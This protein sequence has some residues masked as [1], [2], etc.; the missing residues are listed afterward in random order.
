MREGHAKAAMVYTN[1]YAIIIGGTYRYDTDTVEVML[2]PNSPDD[3]RSNWYTG[4]ELPDALEELSALVFPGGYVCVYGG[5][6]NNDFG[7]SSRTYCATKP[8][9]SSSKWLRKDNLLN[10]RRFHRSIVA[11]NQI[12]HVGDSS[13]KPIEKW[14][15]ETEIG[16]WK[17]KQNTDMDFYGTAGPEIFLL[18]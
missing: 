5:Y 12:F 1:G 4:A 3:V 9:E 17:N 15:V 6:S 13:H 16:A 11:G 14:E 2:Q 18:P 10:P 7:S 8:W